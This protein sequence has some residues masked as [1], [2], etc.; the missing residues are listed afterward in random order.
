MG[1]KN[2]RHFSGNNILRPRKN[3]PNQIFT[4]THTYNHG[5]RNSSPFIGHLTVVVRYSVYVVAFQS[6]AL[7]RTGLIGKNW[8]KGWHE[9]AEDT[10]EAP[11]AESSSHA[12]CHCVTWLTHASGWRHPL[13][14]SRV[15]LQIWRLCT[16]LNGISGEKQCVAT[17]RL[18]R[19]SKTVQLCCV[20]MWVNARTNVR[21]HARVC[22]HLATCECV[23]G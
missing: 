15:F 14:T 17:F 1:G 6:I 20:R 11:A 19:A 10:L 3:G 7:W 4:E 8:P 13:K 16:G 18:H 12:I 5:Y 22:I 21:V 23:A 9:Q 2:N